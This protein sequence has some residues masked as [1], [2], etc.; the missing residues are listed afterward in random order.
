MIASDEQAIAISA[1]ALAE[2]RA[3]EAVGQL[4]QG[5]VTATQN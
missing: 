5:K 1:V 3:G 2:R 4:G